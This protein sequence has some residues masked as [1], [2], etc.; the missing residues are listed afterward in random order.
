MSDDNKPS[1]DMLLATGRCCALGAAVALVCHALVAYHVLG[2]LLHLLDI[3]LPLAVFSLEGHDYVTHVQAVIQPAVVAV[4]VCP[5]P[6]RAL[7][8]LLHAPLFTSNT[9]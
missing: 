8:I 3:H 7:K 9:D 2:A 6:L 5:S 4:I 1:V